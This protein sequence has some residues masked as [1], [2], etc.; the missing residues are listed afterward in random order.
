MAG[1]DLGKKPEDVNPTLWTGD[2]M[3]GIPSLKRWSIE[4]PDKLIEYDKG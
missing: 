2:H 4:H 3:A 1:Q